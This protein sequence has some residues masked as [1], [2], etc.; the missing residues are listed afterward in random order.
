MVF[1]VFGNSAQAPSAGKDPGSEVL[2]SCYATRIIIAKGGLN[3][4]FLTLLEKGVGLI[5]SISDELNWI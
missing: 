1:F 5:C 2:V 3:F 4:I